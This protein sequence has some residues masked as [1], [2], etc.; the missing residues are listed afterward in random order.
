MTI[1][2]GYVPPGIFFRKDSVLK[3]DRPLA[4]VAEG[5]WEAAK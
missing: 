3:Y 4:P 5:D 2:F 1:Q